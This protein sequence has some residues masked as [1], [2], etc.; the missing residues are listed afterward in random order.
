M[1]SLHKLTRLE[2]QRKIFHILTGIF[3]I[4][5]ILA[6]IFNSKV[7]FELLIIAGLISALALR[8]KIPVIQQILNNFERSGEKIPGRAILSALA[9]TL[10]VLELFP[11]DIALASVLILTFADPISHFIGKSFGKTKCILNKDKNIEGNICG[12]IV[13]SVFAMFFVSPTLAMA[14]SLMAMVFELTVIKVQDIQVDDNLIIPVV[15]GMTM[16][17]IPLIISFLTLNF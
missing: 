14:G 17:L 8:I 6:G 3:G 10:L 5:M 13:S 1:N 2:L 4:F 11:R 9:G 12:A 7:L 15:A 16:Y